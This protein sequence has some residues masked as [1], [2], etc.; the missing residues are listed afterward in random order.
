MSDIMI[1]IETL[2]KKHGCI[3]LSIGAVVFDPRG[4]GHGDK[5]YANIRSDTCE[6]VGLVAEPDTVAW[7]STQPQEAKEALKENQIP[8]QSALYQFVT[9]WNA[10]AGVNAWCQG[11]NFDIPILQGAFEACGMIVPWDYWAVR[12]TRTAYDLCGFDPYSIK[13]QG[14]YHKADDDCLHQI[15]CV[16][17]AVSQRNKLIIQ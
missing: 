5:F 17:T 8:L 12:D 9:W 6:Q 10:N 11:L 2:G 14:V 3:I 15:R 1:D 16:Q 7:W 4:T 13:R